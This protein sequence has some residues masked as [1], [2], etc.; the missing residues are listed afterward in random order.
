MHT[1]MP[2]LRPA[3][4]SEPSSL[5]AA[6]RDRS[7]LYKKATQLRPPARG[8]QEKTFGRGRQAGTGKNEAEGREGGRSA[9]CDLTPQ[10][11]FPQPYIRPKRPTPTRPR[12][13][14][15]SA[16]GPT[17]A[18]RPTPL[19]R[20]PGAAGPAALQTWLTRAAPPPRNIATPGRGE[21]QRT[22]A[23][24]LS[25]GWCLRMR[26]SFSCLVTLRVVQLWRKGLWGGGVRTEIGF[27]SGQ[28]GLS[29]GCSE[30]NQLRKGVY[31][32]HN[33]Y[34]WEMWPAF[35]TVN[36]IHYVLL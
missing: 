35:Y 30:V 21:T 34:P 19:R 29:A 26:T 23:A 5:P 16:V 36:G 24:V 9:P 15:L 20:R 11:P 31:R 33:I 14:R 7:S 27:V 32:Q 6:S 10:Q 8:A 18:A 28:V 3:V 13:P 1:S 4:H 22:C 2:G 25:W 12:P 17:C